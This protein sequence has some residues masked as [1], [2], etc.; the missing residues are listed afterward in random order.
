MDRRSFL[1]S[2]VAAGFTVAAIPALAAV[3][4]SVE[5]EEKKRVFFLSELL[6][7]AMKKQNTSV[8]YLM[9]KTYIAR[10]ILAQ[11]RRYRAANPGTFMILVIDVVRKGIAPG[12]YHFPG[13]N[14]LMYVFDRVVLV[15]PGGTQ[16]LLKDRQRNY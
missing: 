16:K 14:G 2:I 5:M 9:N 3:N 15:E 10:H 13:G 4:S 7:E 6:D 12:Q 11:V 8:D 1:K